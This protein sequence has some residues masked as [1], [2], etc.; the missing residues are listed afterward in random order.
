M[1]TVIASIKPTMASPQRIVGSVTKDSKTGFVHVDYKEPGKIKATTLAF[2]PSDL[3]A[4]KTG[5]AGYVVAMTT[6]PVATLVGELVTKGDKTYLKTADGN[7][8]L[9]KMPGVNIEYLPVDAESREARQA[10]K[11]AAVKVRGARAAAKV[12][13]SEAKGGSR[14]ERRAAK[15]A[16]AGKAEKT[17]KAEKPT[18]L[19]RKEAATGVVKKKKR[20]A[21]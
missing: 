18:K 2:D 5:P 4:H 21:E 15:A 3:I 7:V 8:E 6:N 9:S 17:A 19:N 13:A 14:A 10:E 16:K 20:R 1:S 12:G 11:A